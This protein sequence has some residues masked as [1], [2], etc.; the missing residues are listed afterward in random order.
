MSRLPVKL[1][2]RDCL[3]LI[4]RTHLQIRSHFQLGDS[5]RAANQSGVCSTDTPFT[6]S[7]VIEIHPIRPPLV[8]PHR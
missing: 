5:L 2:A 3:F 4:M 8:L 6:I 7:N 1:S